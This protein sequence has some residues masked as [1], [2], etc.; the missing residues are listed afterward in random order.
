MPPPP[1]SGNRSGL[2]IGGGVVIAVL[3]V[4]LAAA[5]ATRGSGSDAADDSPSSVAA[6][7]STSTDAAAPSSSVA[8]STGPSTPSA[9]APGGDLAGLLESPTQIN[10]RM[11]TTMSPAPGESGTEPLTK[12]VVTPTEC[13]G[14]FIPATAATYAGTDFTAMAV[15]GF[16]GSG[17]SMS[18]SVIEVAVKFP[19][20]AA[21]KRF[22]NDQYSDMSNC[23]YK[24]VTARYANG[25]SYDG[26]TTAVGKSSGSE[27]DLIN[28]IVFR[29]PM[30]GTIGCDRALGVNGEVIVDVLV[31]SDG[32]SGGYGT[33]LAR[34]IMRK[35]N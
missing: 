24:P 32:N 25:A 31:C 1:P 26:K 33:G 27:G 2:L 6:A 16:R 19:D 17:N 8:A 30:E 35:L 5:L 11:K 4:A 3:V 7:P 12:V 21:A 15:Q 9:T 22:F 23:T 18:T 14:N 20:A 29:N 34:S 28:T 10:E 13:T